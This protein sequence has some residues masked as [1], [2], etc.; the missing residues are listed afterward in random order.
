MKKEDNMKR[1]FIIFIVVTLLFAVLPSYG[2]YT[3]R[4]SWEEQIHG[5]GY[6]ILHLSSINAI[7]GMNLTPDQARR[8]RQMAHEVEAISEKIPDFETIYR[9]DLAEVRD[10]YLEVRKYIIFGKEVPDELEERVMKARSIESAVI[11]LS[12]DNKKRA[13]TSCARCHTEPGV[14]DVRSDKRIMA[15]LNITSCPNFTGLERET[16]LAHMAGIFG[17]RGMLKLMS[18]SAEVDRLLTDS[19]KE[20]LR[21]FTCCIIPPKELS[22]PVRAG[23]ATSGEKE[24]EILRKVRK[25]PE[26][27]WPYAKSRGLKKLEQL[28]VFKYPGITADKIKAICDHVGEIYEKARALPEVDFEMDKGELAAELKNAGTPKKELNKRQQDYMNALFLFIPGSS[29][30]YHNI[31]KRIKADH[32]PTPP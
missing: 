16:F 18:L 22:D 20:I 2:D 23:Q 14:S 28:L 12:L 21:T 1:T 19:Q 3:S 17:R 10:T 32:S 29:E 6:L 26:T 27:F 11:R 30:V 25:V 24:I 8:L 13:W 31:I 4:A 9:P 5:M 15:A 7:N